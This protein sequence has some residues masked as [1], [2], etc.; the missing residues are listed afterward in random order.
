MTKL[1]DK[2]LCQEALNLVTSSGSAASA[3]QVSGISQRTLRDRVDRAINRH[4]LS[5]KTSAKVQALKAAPMAAKAEP[6]ELLVADRK[7][8]AAKE[9]SKDLA[10][11]LKASEAELAAAQKQL[12]L[13]QEIESGQGSRTTKIDRPVKTDGQGIFCAI[14]SDWHIEERVD[15]RTIVG[16]AN[17]YNPDIAKARSQ[18]FFQSYVFMLNAWREIGHCDTAVLAL[19]GDFISG[20][21]H[22][23]LM[24]SNYM[25]PSEAI[26][27]A[28]ELLGS[29]IEYILKNG[30]LKTLVIPTCYG[31]H[32]RTTVKS[33]IQ[34]G[35][36]NSFEYLLYKTMAREWRNEKRLDWRI[37]DG[38]MVYTDL[39]DTR[40]AWHHGDAVK[41][42]GGVGGIMIPLRKKIMSW[43]SGLKRPIDIACNGHFHTSIEGPDLISNGS[44]I[45]YNAYAM[46]CGCSYEPP[47]Q[48]C[49]W[50]DS[51][52][53]R[54]MTGRLYVE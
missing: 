3:E 1:D 42:G 10:G 54:T 53:G 51:N 28:Q 32:G 31:N 2:T 16:Y 35:A 30:D 11:K 20:F 7:L 38:Y 25:S 48:T 4:G 41:F 52:R 15:P 49:F 6:K 9:G 34:T 23:E 45:G 12:K 24:E 8:T 14:A 18:K 29:G 5:P 40:V 26:L 43:N 50:I 22:E 47:Q 21:I 33:R 37:A 17:E 13:M 27:F 46:N 44:L 19:L 36:E 39:Y